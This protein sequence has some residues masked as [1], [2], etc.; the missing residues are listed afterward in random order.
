MT[1][2]SSKSA[3]IALTFDNY[4]SQLQLAILK[5]TKNAA[6]LPG[7][8]GFYTSMDK[9]LAQEVD[10]C[11][12]RVLALT[13]KMLTLVATGETSTAKSRKR[14]R[15]LENVEDV[16]DNFRSTVIDSMDQ[17]LERAVSHDAVVQWNNSNKSGIQDMRI[18]DV[19]GLNKPPA[20]AVATDET[21]QKLVKVREI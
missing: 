18:D 10:A 16:V 11:S 19:K 20:I 17:L 1:S 8:V 13:N 2:S 3:V 6:A 4:N 21:Q 9:N 14:T 5:A 15:R 7:D 12:T